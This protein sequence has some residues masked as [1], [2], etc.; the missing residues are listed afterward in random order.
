M[1]VWL[2]PHLTDFLLAPIGASA[3]VCLFSILCRV[4]SLPKTLQPTFDPTHSPS[5]L[6]LRPG[7]RTASARFTG[8][9]PIQY[10]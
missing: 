3:E 8:R 4:R 6:F 10:P 5:Q 7:S 2:D 9:K 1:T